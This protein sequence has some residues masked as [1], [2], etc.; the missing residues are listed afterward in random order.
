MFFIPL[1]INHFLEGRN[2]F[3]EGRYWLLFAKGVLYSTPFTIPGS[4]VNDKFSLDGSSLFLNLAE[5]VK[6][7]VDKD[8]ASRPSAK[9]LLESSL[10]PQLDPP[11]SPTSPAAAASLLVPAL[12]LGAQGLGAAAASVNFSHSQFT[13]VT[14]V[15]ANCVTAVESVNN[16]AVRIEECTSKDEEIASLKKENALLKEQNDALKRRL[17]VLERGGIGDAAAAPASLD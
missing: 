8:P 7:L 3:L 14:S 13:S 5:W 2:H 17:E 15:E 6:R 1:F 9:E 12:P 16:C 4:I 10:F 11:P